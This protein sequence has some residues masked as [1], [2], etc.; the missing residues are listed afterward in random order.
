[1]RPKNLY[2]QSAIT[3]NSV[4]TFL[5]WNYFNFCCC[6]SYILCLTISLFLSLFTYE[7]FSG[8]TSLVVYQ[9]DQ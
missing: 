4:S 2:C 8:S 1:M 9:I 3:V 5:L 6:S 7:S